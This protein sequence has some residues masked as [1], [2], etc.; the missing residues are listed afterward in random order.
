L[1]ISFLWAPVF[2]F[3]LY[4]NFVMQVQIRVS[5]RSPFDIHMDIADASQSPTN[6]RG[7]SSPRSTPQKP[8]PTYQEFISSKRQERQNV[9]SINQFRRQFKMVLWKYPK[10][11]GKTHLSLAN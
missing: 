6:G 10:H 8:A 5:R 11:E 7:A 9:P 4:L 2:K 1:D 3:P